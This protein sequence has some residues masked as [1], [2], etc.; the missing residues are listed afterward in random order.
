MDLTVDTTRHEAWTVVGVTGDVDAFSAPT[1]RE[2]MNAVIDGGHVRLVVDLEGVG[3]MDSTG[4]GLLVG[5]LKT[6]QQYGGALRLVVTDDRLLRNFSIT[7]LDRVFE[8]Y[9]SVEAATAA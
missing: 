8:I 7:G 1:L 3:F 6:V 4:L 2:Q 5:R 9:D